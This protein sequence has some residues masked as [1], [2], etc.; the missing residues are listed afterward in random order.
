MIFAQCHIIQCEKWSVTD[1][2]QH[3]GQK[4]K[5]SQLFIPYV[6]VAMEIWIC[7]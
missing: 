2:K 4:Q 7:L 3:S 5:S 1:E 6:N